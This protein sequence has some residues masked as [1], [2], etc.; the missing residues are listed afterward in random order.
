MEYGNASATLE[1]HGRR[2]LIDCGHAVY[3][4][5]RRLNLVQSISHI[6]LTHLHDDHCGSLGTLIFDMHFIRQQRPV[7]LLPDDGFRRQVHAYLSVYMGNPANFV[8]LQLIAEAGM[9]WIRPVDTLGCHMPGMQTYAY[10]FT[11]GNEVIAYSGDLN[12]P[13]RVFS[14]LSDYD[15][16][17]VTVFHE[18]DFHGSPA[19]THYT[20]LH[21]WLE[22]YRIFGYHCDPACEPQDNR[23][24]LVVRSPEYCW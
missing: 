2:I 5:L 8:D 19:H 11:E 4:A 10:V 9:H 24:P 21:A 15:P 23:V 17:R 22:R 20:A 18:V 7:L 13:D 16:K 6:L 14:C 3:P 1:A 12:S